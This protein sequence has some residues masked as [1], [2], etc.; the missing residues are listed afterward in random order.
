MAAFTQQVEQ[1]QDHHQHDQRADDPRDEQAREIQRQR[2][3]G[4]QVEVDHEPCSAP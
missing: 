4:E 3:R 2:A 1:L